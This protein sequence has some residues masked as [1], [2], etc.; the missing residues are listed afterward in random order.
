MILFNLSNYL[1]ETILIY[2][3]LSTYLSMKSTYNWRK[4]IVFIV[5]STI[6]ITLFNMTFEFEGLYALFFVILQYLFCIKY[7]LNRKLECLFVS[8]FAMM[9]I[10]M[11]NTI[12]IIIF[13]FLLYG[14]INS[15]VLMKS[16]ILI[17]MIILSNF[18]FYIST[19]VIAKER[20]KYKMKFSLYE[21]FSFTCLC[22]LS[23]FVFKP[24]EE[25]LY[26]NKFSQ[27]NIAISIFT[28]SILCI[29]TFV[30]FLRLLQ[31]HDE[32]KTNE[33]NK[34]IDEFEA[35]RNKENREAYEEISS[36]KHDLK[37]IL[38][39]IRE[40]IDNN[41]IES[42]DRV[43]SQYLE[44]VNSIKNY[45]V[46]NNPIL[47]YLINSYYQK[48]LSSN[49]EL[50]CEI[51]SNCKM[52]VPDADL[53]VIVG[54]ALE[55]AYENCS[56]TKEIK[57]IIEDRKQY[58]SII[59]ENSVSKELIPQVDILKSSKSEEGHGYGIKSMKRVVE[60]YNGYIEF[61]I[62]KEKFS[63]KLLFLVE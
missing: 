62:G 24:L 12:L 15:T 20:K 35:R 53:I 60:K 63:C 57:V 61:E 10:S 37:H 41:D 46:I 58:V 40:F 13:S 21:I 28:I 50:T 43:I 31:K 19:V 11:I 7:S 17:I 56:G 44:S 52:N 9:L 14:V 6:A 34:K 23:F 18:L 22:G 33:I 36:I 3:F 39:T 4:S 45:K 5:L 27:I 54:N 38:N 2:N 32:D 48:A 8:C 55:N 42:A 1:L 16:S 49:I 47:N 25:I 29:Y 30:L 51:N 26:T 59:I